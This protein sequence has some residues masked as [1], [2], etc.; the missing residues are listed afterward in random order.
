MAY[1]DVD[2][3]ADYDG[4]PVEGN[5]GSRC[6]FVGN[7]CFV[8]TK[9]AHNKYECHYGGSNI[10]TD[11]KE[12][13]TVEIQGRVMKIDYHEVSPEI[14]RS[15]KRYMLDE[16]SIFT[17]T[18]KQ[19]YACTKDNECASD[20]VIAGTKTPVHKPDGCPANPVSGP[21]GPPVPVQ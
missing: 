5:G 8:W 17:L 12:Y 20:C 15:G 13:G 18:K 1:Q 4:M 19:D 14:M 6:F 7:S 16:E 10:H 11:S 9:V 2:V 3:R 21:G